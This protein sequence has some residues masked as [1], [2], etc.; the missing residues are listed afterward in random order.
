[1]K[2]SVKNTEEKFNVRKLGTWQYKLG[3]RTNGGTKHVMT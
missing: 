3:L 1:M 2:V